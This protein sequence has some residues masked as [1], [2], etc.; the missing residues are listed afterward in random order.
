MPLLDSL[1]LILLALPGTAQEP[2]ADPTHPSIVARNHRVVER[3]KTELSES[4]AYKGAD[5]W[6]ID[7]L[8]RNRSMGN[9]TTL[10]D[11]EL[12][13]ALTADLRAWTADKHFMIAHMPAFAAELEAYAKE[14]RAGE[15]DPQDDPEEAQAN[16]GVRR[17][18]MLDGQV[19]I[20]QLDRIAFSPSTVGAF[21]KALAS[22]PRANALILDL[23]DN[24]G[25]SA[26]MVPRLMSCF[27]GKGEAVTL[28][29]RYWRP[30]DA[31]R[32]IE[33]DPSLGGVRYLDHPILVLTSKDTRSA[34]EA[35]A[36]HLRAFGR[37]FVVGERSSGGAHPA[38]MLSLGDGFVA[39]IPMGTVTSARTGTDWEV[40]GVP[41]DVPCSA[42]EA[43]E[44]A[45]A[46]ALRV[47]EEAR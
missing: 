32:P 28:G 15:K 4:Y 9:Y 2:E 24:H 39:L 23:R 30:D 36:Y 16:F 31:H 10:D 34:A 14:P 46:L 6:L 44:K 47:L 40:R 19:G 43:E 35:L 26:D 20:I 21:Q 5:Q 1:C 7:S 13:A 42:A 38:D 11:A 27:F 22:L 33:T 12:G 25:G 3:L 18:E 41:V 45:H 37:A 8:E 29:T 17:A